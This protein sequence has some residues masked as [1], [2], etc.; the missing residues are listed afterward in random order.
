VFST[1]WT[2]R[3]NPH[4]ATARLAAIAWMEGF[5]LLHGQQSVDEF[6]GWRL[7]EVAA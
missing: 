6:V 3:T 7:A 4:L 5:G 1:P 2:L